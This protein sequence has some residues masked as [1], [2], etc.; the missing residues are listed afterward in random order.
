MEIGGGSVTTYRGLMLAYSRAR[1]LRRL[2]LPVPVLT[3]RLSS[4]W[5]HWVT[6]VHAS[7]ARPLVEGLRND[8]IASDSSASKLFPSINPI[9]HQSA[10]ED[11]IEDLEMGRIDTAWSDADPSVSGIRPSGRS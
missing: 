1:G 7:I 11:V 3:P 8:T 6:P 5:V 2:L 9:D 10:I 4:Y